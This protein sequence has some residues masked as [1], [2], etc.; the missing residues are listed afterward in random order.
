MLLQFSFKNF[1]SFKDITVMNFIA[2]NGML[3]YYTHGAIDHKNILRAAA[4]YGANA[5]GKTKLFEAFKFMRSVVVPPKRGGKIPILDYWQTKYAPFRLNTYSSGDNSIF[6]VVV[7]VER[8]QYKYGFELNQ[9]EIKKE[10]LYINGENEVCIFKRDKAKI[11]YN[12]EYINS[13]I[14]DSIISAEMVSPSV[15]FLSVL[16][17]LNEPLA[18]RIINWFE[19]TVVISANEIGDSMPIKA[20][21]DEKRKSYVVKFLK[22]F[23]INIEDIALHEM[24]VDDIPEKVRMMLGEDN[25]K[26][27]V[28][29]GIRTMHKLYNERYERNGN[30]WLSMEKDE[31]YGT[32][33]LMSLSWPILNAFLSDSVIFIDEFDSGIHPLVAQMIVEL[34]YK[35]TTNAQLIINTQNAAFLKY[36]TSDNKRL[37]VK[38]QIFLVSKNRYGESSVSTLSEY[39]SNIQRNLENLYLEGDFGAIPYIV[40][41]RMDEIFENK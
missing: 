13:T 5:S 31:S 18:K 4:V 20:L 21:S 28:Y 14:A 11:D 8:A 19:N 32:N 16:Q 23:D 2:P 3:K 38:D 15:G 35:L 17:T 9:T 7:V 29:D 1:K 41:D 10:W 26:G 6:E 25:I 39:G 22:S 33:R 34:F 27:K 24:N 37:F 30:V 40:L 36:K 12:K